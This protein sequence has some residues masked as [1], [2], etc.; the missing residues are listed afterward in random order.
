MINKKLKDN[1]FAGI[2]TKYEKLAVKKGVKDIELGKVKN[3]TKF[4]LI[5]QVLAFPVRFT[6][7]VLNLPYKKLVVPI[8][9]MLKKQEKPVEVINHDYSLKLSKQ[10]QIFRRN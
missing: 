5:H 9:R 8:V 3:K 6:W 2:A 1:G 10:C 7:S 4:I